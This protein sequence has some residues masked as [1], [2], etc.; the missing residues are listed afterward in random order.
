MIITATL[1]RD[2]LDIIQ[3]IPHPSSLVLHG[4]SMGDKVR[5]PRV[6]LHLLISIIIPGIPDSHICVVVLFGEPV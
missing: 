2:I 4:I 1:R 5:A 6:M 3:M